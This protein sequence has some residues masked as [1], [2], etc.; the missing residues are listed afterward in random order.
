MVPPK[1]EIIGSV[2]GELAYRAD[3]IIGLL[4]V[5]RTALEHGEQ[6]TGRPGT[7]L[8][9]S[10]RDVVKLRLDA[11]Q[12]NPRVSLQRALD[13][14]QVLRVHH[15]LKTWFLLRNP[16]DRRFLTGNICPLLAPLHTFLPGIEPAKLRTQAVAIYETLFPRTSRLRRRL[17]AGSRAVEFRPGPAGQAVLPR[18]RHLFRQRRVH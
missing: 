12:I 11:T 10:G 15:P 13:V 2:G 18:R 5:Q 6:F 14:E 3:Q 4:N 7:A 1:I 17:A 8:H 16:D 9:V